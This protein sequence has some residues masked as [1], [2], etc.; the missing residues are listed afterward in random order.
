MAKKINVAVIGTGNMGRNHVRVFSELKSCNLIA[1]C[2]I[3]SEVTKK[4]SKEFNLKGYLDYKEMLSVEKI[5]AVSIAVPTKIHKEITVYCL[6][7]NI[8]TLVEKPIAFTLKEAKDIIA[9]EKKTKAKLTVG[10]I[11]RFN[12]AVVKLAEIVKKGE[13]GEIISINTKRL[14]PHVPKKRDTGVILDLA[15]HDIDII[16]YLFGKNPIK[17]F[18]N[19]GNF[20]LSDKEDCAEIFLDYGK[21]SG[22]IQVNWISPIKIRE[23]ELTGTRGYAR[24][25]YITQEVQIYKSVFSKKEDG[26]VQILSEPEMVKVEY[27]EPLKMELGSFIN[28]I[29]RKTTPA[30]LP[31]EAE[32]ALNIALKSLSKI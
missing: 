18:A 6:A 31:E 16:N 8:N 7:N 11:E 10:H 5:D 27:K 30:V 14:G 3:N 22:H 29:I 21:A 20:I 24:V 17:I 1:F 26:Y 13:L 19:A 15:V 28:C 23:L 2:D 9:A 12:P 32:N 4:I 25:N